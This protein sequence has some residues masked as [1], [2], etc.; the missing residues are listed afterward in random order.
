MLDPHCAALACS[1][2][3]V[4]VAVALLG[5]GLAAVFARE[6]L[7]SAVD[8][9]VVEHVANFEKL[10]PADGANEDLVWTSS[11]AVVSEYFGVSS[12]L[13]FST[14]LNL[15]V[16]C[17]LSGWHQLLSDGAVGLQADFF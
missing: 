6:G 15:G 2:L 3:H 11:Q 10:A 13:I 9:D 7:R 17:E 16:L 1:C 14:D 8:A 5:E 12:H 4:R